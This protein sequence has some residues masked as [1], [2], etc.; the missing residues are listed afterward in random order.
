M[1]TIT[2][3]DNHVARTDLLLPNGHITDLSMLRE[4]TGNDDSFITQLVEMFL[5]SSPDIIQQMSLFFSA[6]DFDNL[7]SIVHRFKSSLGILGNQRLLDFA[8][9]VEQQAMDKNPDGRLS[10]ELHLLQA[11]T[12]QVMEEL[13]AEL[14]RLKAA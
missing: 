8:A 7:R 3:F 10:A 14:Q 12:E 5:T 9:H 6:G 13:S 4:M 1:N 2:A 11:A